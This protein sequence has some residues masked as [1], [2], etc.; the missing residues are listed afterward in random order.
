MLCGFF[1]FETSTR[2]QPTCKKPPHPPHQMADF[3]HLVVGAG[4]IGLSIASRLAAR[5]GTSVLL[6]ERHNA[7]GTETSARNSEV[8]H[9]GLYYPPESLKT[10]LCIRGKNMIYGIADKMGIEYRRCGKWI[11]AQD[12]KEHEYLEKMHEKALQLGIPTEFVP[13]SKAKDIEPAVTAR[14]AILNS[15]STGIISSHSLME[16]L[17][18]RFEEHGGDLA[19]NTTVANIEFDSSRQLY[20]AEFKYGEEV[21]NL[22]FESVVNAAGHGAP[23]VSNMILPSDRHVKGY[24]AKGSY[25]SYGLSRPKTQRLIYPCPAG[26]AGLGTHLTLDLGGRIRFG[27]NV[28][29]VSSADDLAAEGDQ[30]EEAYSEITKYLPHVEKS[31]LEPDY[32]GIRPKIT[33]PEHKGFV[34][35]V[36][37]HEEGFPGFINLLG[38]ESPGLTSSLAIGEKVDSMLR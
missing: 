5:R 17:L 3:S 19:L 33:G 29:W 8:I 22:R 12:E 31:A 6:V 35:F 34:D 16:Y 28:K 18:G 26:H 20:T 14:R 32:A 37:R 24:F 21:M 11:V 9:A 36:I 13:L 23:D 38:I 10:E 4:V 15:P 1:E 25:F 7:I 2:G 27:P 30:L